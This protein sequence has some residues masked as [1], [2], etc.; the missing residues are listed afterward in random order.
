MITIYTATSLCPAEPGWYV[1]IEGNEKKNNQIVDTWRVIY[2]VL[3]WAI[4]RVQ[5]YDEGRD[6]PT[7]EPDTCTTA[8]VMDRGESPCV[9]QETEAVTCGDTSIL[10]YRRELEAR[11]WLAETEARSEVSA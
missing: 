6:E 1:C 10:S 2:P 3:A 9:A 7:G 11:R 8:L 4:A 5:H